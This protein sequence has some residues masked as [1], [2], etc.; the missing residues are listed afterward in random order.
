MEVVGRLEHKIPYFKNLFKHED[1][2]SASPN[3]VPVAAHTRGAV[4]RAENPGVPAVSAA[5]REIRHVQ[6]DSES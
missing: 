1:S 2:L 6:V 4:R 5:R 3:T